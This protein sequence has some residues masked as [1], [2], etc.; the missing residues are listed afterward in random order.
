MRDFANNKVCLQSEDILIAEIHK[1]RFSNWQ[2]QMQVEKWFP[3]IIICL[4][5][6][7]IAWNAGNCFWNRI[8]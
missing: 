7:T 4:K 2:N 1:C 8:D 6:I 5:P 3:T